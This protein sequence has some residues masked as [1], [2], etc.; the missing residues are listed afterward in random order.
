MLCFYVDD[1][2]VA[3][4]TPQTLNNFFSNIGNQYTVKRL[5][6]PTEFL[7]MQIE[8]F[9]EY[10]SAI[11]HQQRYIN[12]LAKKFHIGNRKFP[13]TPMTTQRKDDV[14]DGDTEFNFEYSA[15]VG[16]LL[17]ACICVRIDIAHSTGIL[18][19]ATQDP[20]PI[21]FRESLRVLAYLEGTDT[22]GIVLGGKISI[23]RSNLTAFVDADWAGDVD[24]R[25][26]TAG[27]V[28]LFN[29]A[30]IDWKSSK[31]KGTI[32][33]SSTEAEINAIT[34]AAQ[35]L[36]F[37]HPIL[38]EMG[39][40]DI[41]AHTVI[42]EDNQPAIHIIEQGGCNSKRAKHYD[43]KVKYV[44]D[45]IMKKNVRIQKV[46]TT[47]QL[48]DFLTKNLATPNFRRARDALMV[49]L[50]DGVAGITLREQFVAQL[51][52]ASNN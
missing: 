35:R 46:K 23:P 4:A 41:E 34:V 3:T 27:L 29:G 49:N 10:N 44:V 32:S 19:R 11:L 14:E 39:H 13:T 22:Y 26:S 12:S 2:L 20:K 15:L 42:M 51:V 37:I 25:R 36:M 45:L 8:Y 24:S 30:A 9:P 50:K 52:R 33:L 47:E 17:F 16:A 40:S 38:R 1:F 7:G 31:I 28:I 43:V 21:N 5:G 48:A 18:S 6:F